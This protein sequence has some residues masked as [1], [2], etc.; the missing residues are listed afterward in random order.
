MIVWHSHFAFQIGLGVICFIDITA[1][2]YISIYIY[3]SMYIS[4]ISKIQGQYMS[5][6]RFFARSWQFTDICSD[7]RV[8]QILIYSMFAS[9][10]VDYF[11]FISGSGLKLD[12]RQ[13]IT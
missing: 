8:E 2:D 11:I 10:R 9:A 4:K 13:A 1:M 12:Q 6:F 3:T 5:V 7:I